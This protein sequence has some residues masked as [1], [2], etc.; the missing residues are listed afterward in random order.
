MTISALILATSE[1]T[2][3]CFS[4][5]GCDTMKKH[6]LFLAKKRQNLKLESR[7]KKNWHFAQKSCPFFVR[8]ANIGFPVFSIFEGHFL[9]NFPFFLPKTVKKHCQ[10]KGTKGDQIEGK[11]RVLEK[12]LI[13]LRNGYI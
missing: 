7:Q 8:G 1:N 9:R 13:P 12:D 5:S 10:K 4:F 11:N 6:S 2:L 3:L